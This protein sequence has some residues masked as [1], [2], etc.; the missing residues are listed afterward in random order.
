MSDEHTDQPPEPGNRFVVKIIG[1]DPP[2]ITVEEL[3][4]LERFAG[5]LIAVLAASND[6]QESPE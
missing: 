2:P 3:L 5:D 6:N 4:L 1:L